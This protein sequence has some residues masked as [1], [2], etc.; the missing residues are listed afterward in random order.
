MFKL[1]LISHIH[2]FFQMNFEIFFLLLLCLLLQEKFEANVN[3]I[4][5][6]ASLFIFYLLYSVRMCTEVML[7]SWYLNFYQKCV[8]VGFCI[9]L[10]IF[11]GVLL[12]R[13]TKAF[14]QPSRVFFKY[15]FDFFFFLFAPLVS[16]IWLWALHPAAGTSILSFLITFQSFCFPLQQ[17]ISSLSSTFPPGSFLSFTKSKV[18]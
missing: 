5:C 15:S 9:N 6:L 10:L 3:F 2:L 17:D 12:I 13:K 4:L 11:G 16:E 18:F 8:N 7:Y 1:S 14:F